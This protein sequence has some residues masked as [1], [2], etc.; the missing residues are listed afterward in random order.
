MP[1]PAPTA[2]MPSFVLAFTETDDTGTP[3]SSAR[4]ARMASM[5][6]RSFGRSQITVASTFPTA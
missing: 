4:R 1:F 3:S 6:G 2:S 5:W